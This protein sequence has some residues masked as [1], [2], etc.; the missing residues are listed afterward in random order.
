MTP[1]VGAG[2]GMAD[3]RFSGYYSETTCFNTVCGDDPTRPGFVPYRIGPQ[4]K[5]HRTDKSN[6][7]L[8]WALMAGAAIDIGS[9]LSLD[10]GYRYLNLGHAQTNLDAFGF[11][12]KLKAVEAHEVRAGFRYMID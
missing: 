6:Q 9:G 5:I 4:G 7:E 11:G 1:Y 2:I 3:N 8:A 12:T 10:L